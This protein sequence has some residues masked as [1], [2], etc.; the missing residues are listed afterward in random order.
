[1]GYTQTLLQWG[2]FP[3]LKFI[4][5]PSSTLRNFCPNANPLLLVH[6]NDLLENWHFGHFFYWNL[7]LSGE[8]FHIKWS[9]LVKVLPKSSENIS[10]DLR[11][12]DS[13]KSIF[14][15][16]SN[17]SSSLN[18]MKPMLSSNLYQI[19]REPNFSSNHCWTKSFAKLAMVISPLKSGDNLKRLVKGWRWSSLTKNG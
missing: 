7:S 3:F 19:K 16:S 10:K 11:W 9:F 4:C 14:N 12:P 17:P 8:L 15:R 13:Y 6:L 1:M 18:L 5:T 2:S